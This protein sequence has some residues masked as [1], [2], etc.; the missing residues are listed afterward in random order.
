MSGGVLRV[1]LSYAVG[2][3][4]ADSNGYSDP[5]VKLSLGKQT[6]KSS[7]VKKSLNPRWDELFSF[8]VNSYHEVANSTLEVACWDWD[9]FSRDDSLGNGAL[10]LGRLAAQVEGLAAHGPMKVPE[11]QGLDDETPLLEDYDVK[12]GTT[13]ARAPPTLTAEA[14]NCQ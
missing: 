7:T 5:Y 10:Q 8:R 1:K 6:F 9:R 4:S 3:K 12:D 11:Q 13:K 2:L 14:A